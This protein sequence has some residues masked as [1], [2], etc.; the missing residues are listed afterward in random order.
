MAMIRQRHTAGTKPAA[1]HS[2]ARRQEDSPSY[3][4]GFCEK[5]RAEDA[6][7]ESVLLRI[8]GEWPAAGVC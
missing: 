3:F 4:P 8:H 1:Q 5:S 6:G 2:D 7:A